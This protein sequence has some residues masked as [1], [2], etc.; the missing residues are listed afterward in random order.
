MKR[1]GPSADAVSTRPT[2]LMASMRVNRVCHNKKTSAATSS[3]ASA[4]RDCVSNSVPTVNVN[5]KACPTVSEVLRSIVHRL[6]LT[7]LCHPATTSATC[8]GTNSTRQPATAFGWKPA[9]AP[10]TP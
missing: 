6:V 9:S 8:N 10:G 3:P 7:R 5:S 1:T 2:T 4:P